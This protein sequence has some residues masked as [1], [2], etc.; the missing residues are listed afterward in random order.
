MNVPV[1]SIL[2]PVY[3]VS[4]FIERCAHSL[5]QQ[6]LN[7]I[8]YVFV[9]DCS[10]DDSIEKLQQII[11]QYPERKPAVKIIHHKKN[12]GTSASRQTAID[13]STGKYIQFVDNDDWLELDMTESLYNKAVKEDADI[14]VCDYVAE[15]KNSTEYHPDYVP[16]NQSDY[17]HC[18]MEAKCHRSLWTKLIVRRLL[19]LPD[20]KFNEKLNLADDQLV[21]ICLYYYAQKIVHV[22][23]TFYHYNR[24]NVN[25]QTY[26]KSNWHYDNIILFHKLVEDFL[27]SKGL[28]EKY[29]ANVDCSKVWLKT[30]LFLKTKNSK[31]RKQYAHI[32]HDIELKYLND[33]RFGEKLIIIFTHFKLHFLAD[34]TI[35]LIRWKNKKHQ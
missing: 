6:T 17:F 7:D 27:S 5:F 16:A 12:R 31:L 11:E 28:Y 23:K 34:W 33:L 32:Y 20:C 3:N 21:T 24:I 29:K 25:A 9:N 4:D 30:D 14:V 19:E 2:I 18:M 26:S 1:V 35:R 22:K 13:N 8:E 10:T 15:K